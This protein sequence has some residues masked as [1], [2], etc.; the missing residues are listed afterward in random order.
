MGVQEGRAC[1]RIGNKAVESKN[2]SHKEEHAYG[3]YGP[4]LAEEVL[5]G[6]K[7]WR[8]QHPR[9]TLREIEG[10]LD[11]RLGK[12]RARMLQDAALASGAANLKGEE[13]TEQYRCPECGSEL[14][15]RTVEVRRLLTLQN[16]TVE[17]KRSYG[18]CPKCGTGLFPPGR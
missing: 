14:E 12:M 5:S 7:E 9:A 6:M 17:L 3:P 1:Q 4:K 15:E 11:E 2:G 18:V 8:L 10:A 13:G 16:R